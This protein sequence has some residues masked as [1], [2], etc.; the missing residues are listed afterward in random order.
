MPVTISIGRGG[1]YNIPSSRTLRFG[2]IVFRQ[3][4]DMWLA[5]ARPN[6]LHSRSANFTYPQNVRRH[7]AREGNNIM[8]EPKYLEV[9]SKI[10]ARL[11]NTNV[12]WAVTGSLDFALWGVPVEVHDIDIQTDMVGAYEME[13]LFSEFVVRK[14]TFSS[15]DR[16]RSHFGALM[17][18]GIKVE[19]MGDIQKRLEDGTWEE[20]VDLNRYKRVVK[21][22]EMQ[23]PVL[24]LEYEYQA[25]LRLGRIEKAEML[26]KWLHDE[27]KT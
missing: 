15:A 6:L 8:I 24:S 2:A 7:V 12:N 22:K 4:A 14:V 11:N 16:I 20:P 21:V 17:V 10:Y 9:L 23:V 1:N 19:I 26:R 27:H 5:N 13:R 25:Y 3:Q 18:D